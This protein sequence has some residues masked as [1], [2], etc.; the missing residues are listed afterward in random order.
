MQIKKERQSVG[1][2][3]VLHSRSQQSIN[4]ILHEVLY[5][6]TQF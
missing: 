6:Y 2:R 1:E 3:S 5:C 4:S